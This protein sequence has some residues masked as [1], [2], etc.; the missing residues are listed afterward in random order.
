[1]DLVRR[2]NDA[3]AVTTLLAA[4]LFTFHQ[5]TGVMAGWRELCQ[6]QTW[7][8][9]DFDRCLSE[10]P[11]LRTAKEGDWLIDLSFLSESGRG[12]VYAYTRLP[13]VLGWR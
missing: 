2:K 5:H 4:L 9:S 6:R 7:N 12:A 10:A 8:P 1:M 13:D 11:T 3:A